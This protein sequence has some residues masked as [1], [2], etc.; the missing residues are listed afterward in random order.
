MTPTRE[1]IRE[2]IADMPNWETLETLF[3]YVIGHWE[4]IKHRK[5][6]KQLSVYYDIEKNMYEQMSKENKE[7]VEKC[8]I[9]CY[10]IKPKY[11]RSKKK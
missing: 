2:I 8:I 3:A 6:M 10:V 9:P 4:Q 7:F 5:Y 1:E 11:K